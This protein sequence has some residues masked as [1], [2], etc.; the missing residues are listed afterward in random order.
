[1]QLYLESPHKLSRY[2][3]TLEQSSSIILSIIRA[4]K[5]SNTKPI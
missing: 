3:L 5:V 1:M 2:F 4:H